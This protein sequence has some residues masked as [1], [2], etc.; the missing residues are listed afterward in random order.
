M[1]EQAK[2]QM[3][4]P[5]KPA[6]MRSY[7]LA[8][9]Q[10]VGPLLSRT[11]VYYN[12]VSNAIIANPVIEALGPAATPDEPLFVNTK[13]HA[14]GLEQSLQLRSD[15]WR[16]FAAYAYVDRKNYHDPFTGLQSHAL[17]VARHKVM[18]G[19]SFDVF[20]TAFVSVVNVFN[21]SVDDE[22]TT[23][24]GAGKEIQR[25]P[26]YNNVTVILGARQLDL[27]DVTVD[28]SLV[29]DNVLNRDN[30]K[31]NMRTA[32]PRAYVQ[33]HFNVMGRARLLF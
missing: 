20:R 32:D 33:N 3:T 14:R 16:G 23:I 31:P 10:R 9:E 1:F 30:L 13:D 27:D 4:R 19:V 8:L 2:T 15:R 24:D 29:F 5:V 21:S 26:Y 11:S 17:D 28:L 22:A 25:V 6:K 18:A 12:D 7:E